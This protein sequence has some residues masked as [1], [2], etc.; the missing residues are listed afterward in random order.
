MMVTETNSSVSETRAESR[1]PRMVNSVARPPNTIAS[2]IV[3]MT[4]SA[5]MPRE[6]RK[7][8]V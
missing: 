3:E 2:T 1:M 7:S 5:G 6:I 8:L 4:P